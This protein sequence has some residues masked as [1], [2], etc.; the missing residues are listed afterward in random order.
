MQRPALWKIAI[1]GTAVGG[2][3]VAGAGTALAD[4]ARVDV[5]PLAVTAPI[6]ADWP[7][8]DLDAR[9]GPSFDGHIVALDDDW[10]DDD[11]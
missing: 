3:T 4:T 6:P 5:A 1:V 7:F 9:V 2:L 10:G 11:D 8:D